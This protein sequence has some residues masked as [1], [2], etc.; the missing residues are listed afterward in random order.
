MLVLLI[1]LLALAWPLLRILPPAYRWRMR[2][3]IYRWYKYLR[4]IDFGLEHEPLGEELKRYAA[5]LDRIE[6]ELSRVEIPM[7]Y[8]EQL[9]NLRVHLSFVRRRL[10]DARRES[11]RA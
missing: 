8:V 5:E 11:A 1:P 3:K 2:R 9:Y 7:A 10:E 6:R 4:A